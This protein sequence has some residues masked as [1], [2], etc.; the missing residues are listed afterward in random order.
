M[1]CKNHFFPSKT[2]TPATGSVFAGYYLQHMQ[3]EKPGCILLPK[4]EA[5]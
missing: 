2:T 5:P 3:S 4:G 1:Y